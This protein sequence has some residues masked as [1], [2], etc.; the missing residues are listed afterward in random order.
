M[1]SPFSVLAEALRALA[2]RP[3]DHGAWLTMAAAL[4]AQG[5]SEEAERAFSIVGL[6]GL[7]G[8]QVAL[9]V[10]CGRLLA[11]RGNV[12]GPELL[13]E[14]AATY[15]Q[16][17][18]LTSEAAPPAP[19]GEPLELPALTPDAE[20]EQVAATVRA[21]L[22]LLEPK[23]TAAGPGKLPAAPLLSSL[24]LSGARALIGVMTARTAQA[25]ERLVVAGEPATS[26]FWLAYGAAAVSRDD[27]TLGELHGGAFFGEIALVGGT[28]R[29]AQVTARTDVWLLEI[30]ARAVE[31]AAHKHPQ[32]ATVLASHAK[33]RLLSNVMRTSELFLELEADERATLLGKFSIEIV[34]A[35]TQFITE[36][37]PNAHLWVVVAGRCEVRSEGAEMATLGPGAAVG[38]ISLVSGKPAVADVLTAERTVLLRLARADFQEVVARHPGLL[39]RVEDLVVTR[40]E[41]NR[42][43]FHDAGDLL[44]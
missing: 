14:I 17:S 12:R 42:A 3:T 9:A 18:G 22:D 36:G 37:Q 23:V 10:A 2:A 5:L 34:E 35:N 4:A 44:V 43:L 11:Q 27:V 28:T 1:S 21:A 13:E 7:R 39:E 25:G 40:E 20:P 33:A 19:H 41:A 26:L 8:G 32:L 15:C 24:P 38:E 30:P 31:A 6:S 29:T 16:G